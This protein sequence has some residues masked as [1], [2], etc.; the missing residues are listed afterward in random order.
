MTSAMLTLN[1]GRSFPVWRYS[2]TLADPGS[3]DPKRVRLSSLTSARDNPVPADDVWARA[4]A[5][6]YD[7][8]MIEAATP[9]KRARLS[10][11]TLR[12]SARG[13]MKLP[14]NKRFFREPLLRTPRRSY[15][16]PR[17]RAGQPRLRPICPIRREWQLLSGDCQ[18]SP[19]QP[20]RG[21][22]CLSAVSALRLGLFGRELA[23]RWT[24]LRPQGVEEGFRCTDLGT[25]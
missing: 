2:M 4:S 7:A 19:I 21:H 14:A 13:A 15:F 18:Q 23:S 9:R 1:A 16:S 25:R 10:P 22:R 17:F 11:A 20:P 8:R 3:F 5:L 24:A 12:R 6:G